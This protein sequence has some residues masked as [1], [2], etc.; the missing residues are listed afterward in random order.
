MTTRCDA[1]VSAVSPGER[2][3]RGGIHEGG[4]SS[5]PRQDQRLQGDGRDAVAVLRQTLPRQP[6]RAEEALPRVRHR[7][8]VRPAALATHGGQVGRGVARQEP[9]PLRLLR[10]G[11]VR[12]RHRAPEVRRRHAV[13]QLRVRQPDQLRAGVR[14]TG[15]VP[16]GEQRRGRDG[17]LLDAGAHVQASVV[18]GIVNVSV[19]LLGAPKYDFAL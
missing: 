2:R 8:Q 14:D 12:A 18:P 15:R 16:E 4:P 7:A 5:A 9:H 3:Q 19:M 11:E 10:R 1:D 6:G 13:P 17:H